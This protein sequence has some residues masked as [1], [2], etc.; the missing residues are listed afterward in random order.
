VRSLQLGFCFVESKFKNDFDETMLKPCTNQVPNKYLSVEDLKWN[1]ADCEQGKQ[2]PAGELLYMYHAFDR[3]FYASK[4]FTLRSLGVLDNKLVR[5]ATAVEQ[6]PTH[7]I[8]D[9]W[10]VD[11][12]LLYW[13][14]E[15]ELIELVFAEYKTWYVDDDRSG[16]YGDEGENDNNVASQDNGID[17]GRVVSMV[18]Q[19]CYASREAL[20]FYRQSFRMGET[21][22]ST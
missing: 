19:I 3:V 2:R 16:E 6:W 7:A 13:M 17:I 9:F 15:E 1:H 10:F 21:G 14:D 20:F 5:P 11:V 4:H 12:V 22:M 8:M 18:L